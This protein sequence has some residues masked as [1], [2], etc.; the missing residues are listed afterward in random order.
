MTKYSQKMEYNKLFYWAVSILSLFTNLGVGLLLPEDPLLLIF[1]FY[2]V[3]LLLSGTLAICGVYI[4]LPGTNI[5]DSP[6]SPVYAFDGLDRVIKY[7]VKYILPDSPLFL[8]F[9]LLL[10]FRFKSLE[11]VHSYWG[12]VTDEQIEE[13]NNLVKSPEEVYKECEQKSLEE[14]K[15]RRK[16]EE[17]FKLINKEYY[18]NFK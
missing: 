10:L 9:P 17:K 6:K 14:D 8:I 18:A 11:E 1:V 5:I 4:K 2:I 16:S 7:E 13:M 3:V 15:L 12:Y